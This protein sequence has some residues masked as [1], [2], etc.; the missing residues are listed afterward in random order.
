MAESPASSS[1]APPTLGLSLG[2]VA[3]AGAVDAVSFLQ[4]QKLYVSFMSGNT[5]ALGVALV[6]GQPA[7]IWR[8]SLV[9][10]LFVVGVVLGTWLHQAVAR[11]PAAAVLAV[12]AGL[13][14]LAYG[15]PPLAIASLALGMGMLN[16][17]V[18][19]LGGANVGLTYVTGALVKMGAGLA[20]WLSGRSGPRDW[21]WQA[22]GWSCF[23]AGVLVG[24]LGLQQLGLAT[25]AGAGAWALG[26]AAV[27]YRVPQA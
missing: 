4:F 14:G 21:R 20:D 3:L 9:L 19:Q 17:S 11:R 24:A 13:L 1:A 23:V 26:L 2:I 12:V 18:H 5:T 15:Y 6:K 27:A 16:A 8:L 22:L 25:L 7:E 10:A